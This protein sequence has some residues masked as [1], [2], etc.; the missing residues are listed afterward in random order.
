MNT[1]KNRNNWG[2]TKEALEQGAPTIKG[3]PIGCGKGYKIDKHYED[4]EN[5][6]V[7]HFTAW[8]IPSSYMTATARIKDDKVWGLLESKEWG[9]IS[10]VLN[11]YA[12]HCSQC[13]AD[14]M[15]EFFT[16]DHIKSK[17]AYG[18]VE[19]FKFDR[20]DFV[21]DPAYPQAGIMDMEATAEDLSPV[22]TL[23]AG[24][25][26]GS[27]SNGP[28][29]GSRSTR[30]KKE[31]KLMSVEELK[32]E[33]EEKAEE[34]LELKAEAE[35]V[36]TLEAEVLELKAAAE[37]GDDDVDD[38]DDPKDP[39]NKELH[40]RLARYE[41]A[42]HQSLVDICAEARFKAGLATDLEEEKERLKAFDDI[43]LKTL[44]TDASAFEKK[45]KDATPRT[46]KAD[47]E[48]EEEITEFEASWN[49]SKDRLF[50]EHIHKRLVA[51]MGGPT[52]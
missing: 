35:K 40:D 39:T 14:I 16:H 17:K 27:Q 52:E 43:Y 10:T 5:I 6:N 3:K 26:Q 21:D 7:G 34:I 28:G 23:A 24:Y 42:S 38:K 32:A 9:A 33:L 50:P 12:A 30:R 41:A 47:Y 13:K 51:Q 31:K 2:V 20:V 45:V 4:D 37:P 19:S 11:V 49:K 15:D 46:P 1:S 48:G 8:K 29:P 18:V 25:Y 22:L 44:T 36:K